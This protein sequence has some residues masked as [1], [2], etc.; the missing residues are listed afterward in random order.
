MQRLIDVLEVLALL[1]GM[2]MVM[3]VGIAAVGTLDR[4][5]RGLDRSAILHDQMLKDHVQQLKEHERVMERL[6]QR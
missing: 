6:T 3:Y 1:V 2:A 4:L 5:N